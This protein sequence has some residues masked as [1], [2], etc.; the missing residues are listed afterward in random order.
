MLSYSERC[1]LVADFNSAIELEQ[2]KRELENNTTEEVDIFDDIIDI[3]DYMDAHVLTNNEI[4][5]IK[6]NTNQLKYTFKR[7]VYNFIK[8]GPI[9]II[10]G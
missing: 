7:F 4:T 3:N 1:A 2:S 9:T 5:N 8:K 10:I 6:N